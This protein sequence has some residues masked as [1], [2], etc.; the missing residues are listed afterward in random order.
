MVKLEDKLSNEIVDEIIRMYVTDL[1]SIKDIS[2]SFSELK[3]SEFGIKNML[4]RFGIEIR[5]VSDSTKLSYKY[6]VHSGVGKKYSKERTCK[7]SETRKK[8]GIKPTYSIPKGQKPWN[9]GTKGLVTGGRGVKRPQMTGKNHYNWKGGYENKLHH[10]RLRYWRKVD[11]EGSIT[12]DEWEQM[13]ETY[14]YT[15]PSCLRKEPEIKLTI[16]HIRPL[17][18]G[19]RSSIENIQPLCRSCNSSK[20]DSEVMFDIPLEPNKN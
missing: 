9:T 11:S 3:I 12:L 20:N 4:R 6:H 8:K 7:Q 10:N 13:K 5:S 2:R 15:C 14:S 18:R 17:S 16:D 19:G 1:H